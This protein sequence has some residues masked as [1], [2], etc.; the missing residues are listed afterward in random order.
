MITEKNVY[1]EVETLRGLGEMV[2]TY[3]AVA[4]TSMKRIRVSVL[5]TREFHEGLL[6]IFREFK[7]A[8]HAAKV[9]AQK[10]L[11]P[12]G[13]IMLASMKRLHVRAGEGGG[14]DASGPLQTQGG[15]TV[16]VVLS[17]NTG[18]YGDIVKKTFAYFFDIWR[19]TPADVVVIGKI[20]EALFRDAMPGAL[21]TFFFFPDNRIDTDNLS[22][23][24]NH[25]AVY[26]RVIVFY[27]VFKNFFLQQPIS[28][29]ISGEESA[30]QE[31]GGKV[32]MFLFEPEPRAIE[33]FFKSEIFASLL[34]QTF[35]DARLS[36]LASR[37]TLLDRATANIDRTVKQAEFR[38]Q[39]IRHRSNN[40]RQLDA[41][42]GVALW[43]DKK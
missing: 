33:Q 34:E 29:N 2:E 3:E 4:A 37:M 22:T 16:Y 14:L 35:Q 12:V 9:A 38:Y 39:M 28:L 6:A 41:I 13:K 21:Y 26:D 11:L 40:R 31:E 30:V 42:S 24:T 1:A 17:A 19:R 25:L 43:Q 20:G 32:R 18:L 23:I 5:A 36:R 8:Y 27:P 10:S 7:S 15:K